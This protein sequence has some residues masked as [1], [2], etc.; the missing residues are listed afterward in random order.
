LLTDGGMPGG[1]PVWWTDLEE[2]PKQFPEQAMSIRHVKNTWVLEWPTALPP[3]VDSEAVLPDSVAIKR[4]GRGKRA[5]ARITVKVAE[6][7]TAL[8]TLKAAIQLISEHFG[9]SIDAVRMNV[10]GTS[11]ATWIHAILAAAQRNEATKPLAWIEGVLQENNEF[12]GVRSVAIQSYAA[13]PKEKVKAPSKP[14]ALPPALGYCKKRDI[15]R[16]MKSR[17]G[18]F[19]FCYQRSLQ[20]NPSLE[21][22]IVTRFRI[23]EAGQVSNASVVLD[24]MKDRNVPKCL[25]TNI[26]KLKFPH[27]EGG[28]CEVRWPFNFQSR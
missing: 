6:E 21:G 19:K 24:T 20:M 26:K 9:L 2:R 4:L 5:R 13:P 16:V 18:A 14:A 23:N 27:P 1:V 22:K 25:V 10:V 7:G 12:G 17:R 15:E 3:P 28:E 11:D 8:A